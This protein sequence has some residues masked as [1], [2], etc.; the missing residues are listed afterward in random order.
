MACAAGCPAVLFNTCT[1][2]LY[3][4]V[5]F[6]CTPPPPHTHGGLGRVLCPSLRPK[7]PAPVLSE[8]GEREEQ[9]QEQEEEEGQEQEEEEEEQEEQEKQCSAV[10]D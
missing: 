2:I 6:Y 7:H 3:N 5:E 9:G 4:M 8:K 1:D 10:Q